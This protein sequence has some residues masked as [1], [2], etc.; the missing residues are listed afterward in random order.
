MILLLALPCLNT[1]THT[2]LRHC[3]QRKPW[4]EGGPTG[5]DP[6]SDSILLQQPRHS[7]QDA[8]YSTS[9]S[10]L[11]ENKW[12]CQKKTAFYQKQMKFIDH[13]EIPLYLLFLRKEGLQ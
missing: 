4:G 6:L 12:P 8:Y 9:L 11:S 1:H 5:K 10:H 3:Q 7:I 13:I 2:H